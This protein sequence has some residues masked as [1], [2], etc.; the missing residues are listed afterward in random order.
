MKMRFRRMNMGKVKVTKVQ[1]EWLERY[2]L[3]QGQIDH[4]IDLQPLK[5]RPDSP[6]VDW[7]AATLARALYNGY[8]VEPVFEVGDWVVLVPGDYTG[9]GYTDYPGEVASVNDELGRVAAIFGGER[10][11]YPR[12]MLKKINADEVPKL[13][14]KA[15]FS[16]H[17]REVQEFKTNDIVSYDCSSWGG[18]YIVYNEKYSKDVF[19]NRLV[20]VWNSRMHDGRVLSFKAKELEVI[21][22]AE[23]RKDVA[24]AK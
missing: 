24:H 5:K 10:L 11:V 23:D 7:S 8:E 20:S 22:F 17:D 9:W 15:W 4:Y 1:A 18:I 13:K 12:R 21:C 3:T 6:I 19:G 16:K 2:P 14:E